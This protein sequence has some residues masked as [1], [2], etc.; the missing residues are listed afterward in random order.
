MLLIPK[1]KIRLPNTILISSHRLDLLDGFN[2]II[3]IK[4]GEILFD[5]ERTKLKEFHLDKIY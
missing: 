4:K 2:R 5:V 3:G 1:N